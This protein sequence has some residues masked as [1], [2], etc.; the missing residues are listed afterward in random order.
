MEKE[1]LAM[2]LTTANDKGLPL[3]SEI[4][5]TLAYTGIRVGELMCIK[6]N[7]LIYV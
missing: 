4:F 5:L 2:F 6:R 1:A 7:R 3:D